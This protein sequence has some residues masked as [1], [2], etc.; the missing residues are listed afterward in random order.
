MH[1]CGLSCLYHMI[2][3]AVDTRG[4]NPV[5]DRE[6]ARIRYYYTHHIGVVTS[7]LDL[8]SLRDYSNQSLRSCGTVT[9]GIDNG[10]R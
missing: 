5:V 10:T 8:L 9:H 1:D 7:L 2:I 6:S 4:F 3:Q